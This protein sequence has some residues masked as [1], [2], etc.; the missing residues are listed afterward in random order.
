[1]KKLFF[2]ALL[3]AVGTGASFAQATKQDSTKA[4]SETLVPVSPNVNVDEGSKSH[5]EANSEV[6]SPRVKKEDEQSVTQDPKAGAR[7]EKTEKEVE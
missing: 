1:M 4:N 7:D 5:L 6:V 2:S 3:L